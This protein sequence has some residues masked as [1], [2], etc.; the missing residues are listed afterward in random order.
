M[1]DWQSDSVRM[2]ALVKATAFHILIAMI[3]LRVQFMTL[4]QRIEIRM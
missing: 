4:W 1:L 2:N 3:T